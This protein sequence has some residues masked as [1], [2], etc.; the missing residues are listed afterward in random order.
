MTLMSYHDSPSTLN[1]A[2]LH[3][4]QEHMHF[5][6]NTAEQFKCARLNGDSLYYWNQCWLRIGLDMDIYF[7]SHLDSFR[8][9]TVN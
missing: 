5:V 2:H 8:E 3:K 4:K 9:N 6:S 1:P 7:D